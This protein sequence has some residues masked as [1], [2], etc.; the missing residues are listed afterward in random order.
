MT[1]AGLTDDGCTRLDAGSEAGA[2]LMSLTVAA[3][4]SPTEVANEL[5]T[6]VV[7]YQS[8]TSGH[9]EGACLRSTAHSTERGELR[10]RVDKTLAVVMLCLRTDRSDIQR[11]CD[12]VWNH[13][14]IKP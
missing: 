10:V 11:G 14:H 1:G 9:P 3:G 13:V 6:R 5:A 12:V 8:C 7:G 4:R 2:Y